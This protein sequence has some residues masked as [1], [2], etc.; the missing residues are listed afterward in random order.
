LHFSASLS[1]AVRSASPA[2]VSCTLRT[3]PVLSGST[4][5]AAPHG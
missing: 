4:P 1:Q 3:R 5:W 2:C